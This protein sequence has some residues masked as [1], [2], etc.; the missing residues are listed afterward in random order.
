MR[1]FL[2]S[3]IDAPLDYL[4]VIDEH[5]ERRIS[6]FMARKAPKLLEPGDQLRWEGPSNHMD[7]HHVQG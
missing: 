2:S 3:P 1:C 6:I 7:D 5:V 4:D